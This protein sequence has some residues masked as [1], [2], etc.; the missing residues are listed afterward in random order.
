MSNTMQNWSITKICLWILVA[1]LDLLQAVATGATVLYA[2]Y[3]QLFNND[4]TWLLYGIG[5]IALRIGI[6]SIRCFGRRAAWLKQRTISFFEAWNF[7]KRHAPTPQNQENLSEE[8]RDQCVL[9]TEL[10]TC[11]LVLVKDFDKIRT[12]AA[13]VGAKVEGENFVCSIY[14]YSTR[15]DGHSNGATFELRAQGNKT[16]ALHEGVQRFRH[17]LRESIQ[18]QTFAEDHVFELLMAHINRRV[19]ELLAPP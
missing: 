8:A 4:P 10:G 7:L 13:S 12:I 3:E 16:I 14:L 9:E 1:T 5:M 15:P 17:K 6:D 2:L 19:K 11:L 18:L